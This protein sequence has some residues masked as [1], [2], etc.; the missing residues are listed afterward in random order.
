MTHD[1]VLLTPRDM[2]RADQLAAE[3]GVPTLELMENAGAAVVR[4]I[5]ARY[6]KTETLVLCGP[7]NNGGDG[8]V[9]ARLLLDRGWPVRLAS[10]GGA[11]KLKG[12][13]AVM[14]GRWTGPV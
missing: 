10:F 2:A 6:D 8:Y 13:A 3:A 11:D 12:D 5:H 1:L 9:I 4:A 7:G 14:A